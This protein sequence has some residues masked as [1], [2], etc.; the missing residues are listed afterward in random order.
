MISAAH[1]NRLPL[2]AL[3]MA[4]G[5]VAGFVLFWRTASP[6]SASSG[7][8]LDF[9]FPPLAAWSCFMLLSRLAVWARHSRLAALTWRPTRSGDGLRASTVLLFGQKLLTDL[10]WMFLV[11]G[12]L[13]AIPTMA[14]A[15]ADRT[16]GEALASVV[17]YTYV[18]SSMGLW[19]TLVMVPVAVLRA[20]ADMRPGV[21]ALLAPPWS[22]LAALGVGYVLLANGGVLDVAFGFKGLTHWVALVVVLGFSYGA[23]VLR[24]MLTEPIQPRVLPVLRVQLLLVE[25]AWIAV[26]LGAVAGLPSTVESV[27][28]GHFSLDAATAASYVAGLDELTSPRAYAVMLPFALVRIAGV[29]RPSVDRILGFPVGRLTLWA[30]VY[31]MFSGNGI[32]AAAFQIPGSQ[33]MAVLTLALG[34]SYLASIMRNTAGIET[35]GRLWAA[36]S[37]SLRLASAGTTALAAGLAVWVFLNHI[38]VINAALLDHESTRDVG[39]TAAAY[40]SVLFDARSTLAALGIALTFAWS[41]PWAR[42][43]GTFFRMRPMLN[44]VSYG[45][46]GFLAW[47]AGAT[48]SSMGHGFLLAGAALAS[49][50]LSLALIQVL[51]Y[52]PNSQ[53]AVLGPIPRWLTASRVR[54]VVLGG[55]VAVYGLLLRPVLYESLW[56]AA[57]YEY[58]ALLALLVMALMFLMD[59]LRRDAGAPEAREAESSEW[60]YH[61]QTLESKEDPR[62]ALT[63]AMRQQFVDYGEWKPLWSYIMGLLYHNG[64]SQEWMRAVCRPLRAGAVSSSRLPFLKRSNLRRLGRASA[65]AEALRRTDSVLSTAPEPMPPVTDED[66]RRAGMQFVETGADVERLAVALIVAHCQQGRDLQSAID[67]WFP[68]LDAPDPSSGRFTLPWSGSGARLRHRHERVWLVDGAAAMVFGGVSGRPDIPDPADLMAVAGASGASNA[69]RAGG[70]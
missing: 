14:I 42:N 18:F 58:I 51:E 6:L 50:M 31:V 44:A 29:F 1:T 15:V 21:G 25:T 60:S 2:T 33:L 32:L 38:P 53:N 56:F 7:V 65:L 8:D 70:A 16:G 22:R 45:A 55:A 37:V 64:A 46:A 11:L 23:L 54:A 43:D 28:V 52:A 41:L 57:L 39:R 61:H 48:L 35:A 12:L 24:R 3:L 34:L 19:G 13:S 20:V 67:L 62:S 69:S 4:A 9:L 5:L 36:A 49:G 40:L 17:P 68:L 30:A 66:V 27:L 59:L 26:A 63:A 10:A 47:V